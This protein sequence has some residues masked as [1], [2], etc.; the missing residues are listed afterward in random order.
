MDPQAFDPNSRMS[1]ALL[2]QPAGEVA[3]YT[4]NAIRDLEL[5]LPAGGE[6]NAAIANARI[7]GWGNVAQQRQGL[8]RD[9]LSGIA[10]LGQMK[11]F[12]TA[13]GPLT[14][15]GQALAGN[16]TQK[17]STDKN[18]DLGLKQIEAGK[19][20]SWLDAFAKIGAALA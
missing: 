19:K 16:Y 11:T 2:A 6:R 4:D 3:A 12:N 17:Y 5:S 1:W 15:S 18:Y 10:N 9:A 8:T 13:L 20:S 14:G 7:A